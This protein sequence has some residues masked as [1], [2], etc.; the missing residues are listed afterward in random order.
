M[1]KQ[2]CPFCMSEVQASDCCPQCGKDVHYAG[3]PTHL[4]AGFALQGHHAYVL[5]AAIGQGGFGVTYIAWDNTINRRVAVKEYFPTYC[6]SRMAGHSVSAY[7]GQ[8]EVYQKGKER[9]LDEARM[10]KS[11]SDLKSVVDVLDFFEANNSAYLVMEFL[12]G[13]SLKEHIQQTGKLPAQQFL[14]QTGS[15]MEDM[16]K[17][18]RRGVVHRDIAPD[19]IIMLSSGQMKLI[20]FGAARSYVGDKSMTVVVKKGFAPVEQYMRKGSNASTDVYALAAT[21][22]YCITGIVPP[23]S[24]ERQYGEAQLIAPSL[25]GADLLPHQEQAL[26]RALEI[27]PR[28]RT[29]SVADFM[30]ALEAAKPAAKNAEEVSSKSAVKETENRR[31][32]QKEEKNTRWWILAVAAVLILSVGIAVLFAGKENSV[33]EVSHQTEAEPG[34]SMETI[35]EENLSPEAIKYNEAVEL[36]YN[37]EYG[38][39]AIAFAKLGDYR[40]AK[41]IS[42][43]IWDAIAKR[44]NIVAAYGA[45]LA[46]REDG[47]V[48]VC[49]NDA[50]DV[51]SWNNIISI[52]LPTNYGSYS[53]VA[54]LCADGTVV[55]SNNRTSSHEIKQ[56]G[57]TDIVAIECVGY[58]LVGLRYDGTLVTTSREFPNAEHWVT[59]EEEAAYRKKLAEL[60]DIMEFGEDL[61]KFVDGRVMV[62]FEIF[63]YQD[64]IDRSTCHDGAAWL[65]RDGTVL[66][67]QNPEN[68]ADEE[69]ARELSS[70]SDI[71]SISGSGSEQFLGLKADGTVVATGD[72]GHK[73]LN[74]GDW[75]DIVAISSG[76][77]HSVGLKSDGTL[78]TSGSTMFNAR[79]PAEEWKNLKL[80][81]N[82]EDLLDQIRIT[83]ITDSEGEEMI[84]E[85]KSSENI[86]MGLGVSDLELHRISTRT[87]AKKIIPE[88]PLFNLSVKRKEV[89]SITFQSNLTTAPAAAVDASSAGNGKVKAWAVKNG[90]LYDVFVTA[91]GNICTQENCHWLFGFMAN[92]EEIHFNDVL[93]TSR[94]TSLDRLFD[95]CEKLTVLDLSC[96][97]TSA[98]TGM[99]GM[100]MDC[101]QL[102]EVDVTSF[103]TSA[104]TNM[105]GMFSMCKNLR[106]VDLTGFDT[107]NVTK[108]ES[109]FLQCNVLEELDLRSFDVSNVTNALNM[110]YKCPAPRPDWYDHTMN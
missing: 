102:E 20:D 106:K 54:G 38:K 36:F 62:D 33:P 64:I 69:M 23:D 8:E 25:L 88:Y 109:M 65:N 91:D 58:H 95:S 68:E 108:T 87:E 77:Y 2:F 59:D 61:A 73:Q 29:Q 37:E 3:D 51:D 55:V 105:S 100:F 99:S 110:F 83:Y 35:P 70:W 40:D 85:V 98:A 74:V 17:M 63:E 52:A 84:P 107:S 80:P 86:L 101:T 96:F 22:Y 6:S 57:W 93:D 41:E 53:P 7:R 50:P 49:G 67:E 79:K 103:D 60:S 75:T 1:H 45:T 71:M 44:R 4:P 78:V 43:R 16:E 18:H 97:D 81:A 15:M 21:I 90:E 42:L 56:E 13:L 28:D 47:T 19:N 94:A 5:G 10:L 66:F 92:L 12:D 27:Q 72:N 9:F 104:V 48:A 39:A 34:P 76:W 32:R 26:E 89:R 82:R 46:I 11:L 14:K 24:A 30:K 31:T